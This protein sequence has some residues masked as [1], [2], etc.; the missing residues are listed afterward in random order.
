MNA[1]VPDWV[2]HKIWCKGCGGPS[3]E[4]SMAKPSAASPK[5]VADGIF[6]LDCRRCMV[7]GK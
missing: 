7:A 6:N 2:V 3:A 1:R 4:V 5:S